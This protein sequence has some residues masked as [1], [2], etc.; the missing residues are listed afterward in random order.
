V[1]NPS[2]LA[3]ADLQSR[4]AADLQAE[5][6]TLARSP[7]STAK[8]SIERLAKAWEVSY[9]EGMLPIIKRMD[10]SLSGDKWDAEYAAG[11]YRKI[12]GELDRRGVKPQPVDDGREAL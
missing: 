6:D 1:A 11:L 12:A 7:Q 2:R 4:F 9:G 5:A 8:Q 3:F 10:R